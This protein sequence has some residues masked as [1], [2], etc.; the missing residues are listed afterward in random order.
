MKSLKYGENMGFKCLLCE[1]VWSTK[2]DIEGETSIHPVSDCSYSEK[3]YW[4]YTLELG[5]V[6]VILKE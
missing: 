5:I 2:G 4:D 3:S 1:L 6:P